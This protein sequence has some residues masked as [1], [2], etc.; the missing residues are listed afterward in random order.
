MALPTRL[1]QS[2]DGELVRVDFGPETDVVAA[3]EA[4]GYTFT[5]LNANPRQRLE[6]QGAP[7]FRELC[8][9]M[10][11]GDALRYEDTAAYAAL[12]A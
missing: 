3:M 2:V 11:D 12:S 1:I 7:K 6:L 8:G 9:P 5:G 4:R 10:W